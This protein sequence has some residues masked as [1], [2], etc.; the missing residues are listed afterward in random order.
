MYLRSILSYFAVYKIT[1]VLKDKVHHSTSKN[2]SYTC[3]T[4]QVTVCTYNPCSFLVYKKTPVH[5]LSNLWLSKPYKHVPCVLVLQSKYCARLPLCKKILLLRVSLSVNSISCRQWFIN[6]I[7]YRNSYYLWS[8]FN[9]CRDHLLVSF[10]DPI[11]AR[12]G[13]ETDRCAA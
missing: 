11:W 10:P 4:R 13:N 9:S 1:H 2:H 6:M 8:S 3:K 5:W 12:S 7:C